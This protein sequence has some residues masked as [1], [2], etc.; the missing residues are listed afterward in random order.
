M[1]LILTVLGVYFPFNLATTPFFL[2]P[3]F[4]KGPCPLFPLSPCFF[5]PQPGSTCCHRAFHDLQFL[6]LVPLAP[7]FFFPPTFFFPVCLLMVGFE[8]TYPFFFVRNFPP[9]PVP[10]SPPNHRGGLPQLATPLLLQSYFLPVSGPFFH[11]F[12]FSFSCP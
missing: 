2:L 10:F 11:E 9:R 7:L 4:V 1:F 6:T 12:C 3:F 8:G 5:R